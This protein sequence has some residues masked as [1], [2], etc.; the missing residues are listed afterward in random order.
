V[1][2][3]YFAP[4]PRGL[5]AILRSELESLGA[6]ESAAVPGGVSFAG[7]ALLG[8]RVNLE[9]RIA[10]RV[11]R[12]VFEGPYATEEDV[13]RAARGLAWDRW[14]DVRRT[15]KV[16]V[17]AQ[18]CR[19]KSLEF[20]TLRI[21]DAVCDRFRNA[22]RA[23]PAVETARPDIRI[24]AYLTDRTATLYLDL[25][26]EALFKRGRRAAA[27]EA[28]IRENL[29]AGILKLSGW[30]PGEALLDPMCGSGTILMEAA[31]MARNVAPG[32]GRSFAFEKL[33]D[34]DARAWEKMRE[35]ARA[36][37]TSGATSIFGSDRDAEAVRAAKR[38]FEAAG[39]ADAVSLKAE[40][41][42]QARAP[43]ET[44]VLAAN[45]PYGV[46]LGD[47]RA[48]AGFYPSLGDALKKNFAG[49]RVHLFS[50][51][52]RLPKLIG[53]SSSRRIPLYNG[54][55]ECRLYEFRMVRGSMR[56]RKKEAQG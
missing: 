24:D 13:Y 12:R 10:S 34:F 32:L 35:S 38:N 46:R 31:M 33:K 4:C 26:G 36:R 14:F 3:S 55:L 43:S 25:S 18:G 27:V 21:K 48:L 42:L 30:T 39:L 53:L 5:E 8:C 15:I 52:R 45:P 11:L 29:A 22:V 50:A 54:A 19:L 37:R 7:D 49:W 56:P 1:I 51:D 9:S 40:D 20:V 28:P 44:G 17:S 2:E 16:K 6:A 41:V 47:P 23:R